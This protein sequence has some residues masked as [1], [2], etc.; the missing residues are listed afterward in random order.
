MA[1]QATKVDEARA[2]VGKQL[3]DAAGTAVGKIDAVLADESSGTVEW[4]AVRAGRF[5]HRALVPARDAVAAVDSVWVPFEAAT[6]RAAPKPPAG[7][8]SKTAE[9]ELLG[10][11]GLSSPAGRAGEIAEQPADSVTSQPI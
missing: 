6:I 1:E 7:G 4:L 2:W 11:Y 10:H 9:L 3:E 5:G 8:L